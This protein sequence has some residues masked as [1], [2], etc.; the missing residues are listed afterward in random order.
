MATHFDPGAAAPADSGIFGLPHSPE[1]AHVVLIPVPFEATTSYGGGT[2]EGP[3]AVLQASRQV[4]LF[5]VETGRPYERGIALLPESE[6]LRAWNTRAKERAQIV[7]EAGGVNPSQPELQAAADEVNQLCEKMNGTV[8]RTAKHWL[9]Q[10]KRVGAIGGD[11]SISY[12]IIQAHAEKYPG[13]GVLHL[14]AHADLRNAYEGFT[15]SHAS[16]MYNVV[17]RLPGVKSLV[18][19]AVRDMSEEENQVIE[20]SQGRIRS[21]F[22]AT[23]QQKRFDGVPWNRQVDE[24]ISLLPEHVYLSFD[25]D[26]L[27]PVLCPHT[28][29]PV[30]GGLSFPE[31]TALLAGVIRSG[32]TIVGFDLTEVA[33]DPEGGEWDGN[34]GARLLYKMIGWMLKSQRA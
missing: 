30:P 25:I 15:W 6:E 10:G 33:P 24:L 12:G 8:Y 34:V 5:D 23:L 32:R 16:I 4:D 14:D 17:K 21:F 2:S 31:A 7:I 29:T 1:E 28:G 13:L 11:H 22:D 27:D 20:G 9:D 3:A 18:Q 26:G 19:V